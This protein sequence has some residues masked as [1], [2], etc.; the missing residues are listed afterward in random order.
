MGPAPATGKGAQLFEE[1]KSLDPA[2]AREDYFDPGAESWDID[3]L[4]GDTA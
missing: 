1:L 4:E 3:G 2:A